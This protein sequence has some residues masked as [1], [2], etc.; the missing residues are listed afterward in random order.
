MHVCALILFVRMFRNDE[1]VKR[2]HT[3]NKKNKKKKSKSIHKICCCSLL[4]F[5]G[6]IH[7]GND[8]GHFSRFNGKKFSIIN[9]YAR[10]IQ[11]C[12]YSTVVFYVQSTICFAFLFLFLLFFLTLYL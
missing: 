3:K 2:K 8:F 4:I 10:Q 12:R 9:P 11:F 6:K 1:I 7:F 5:D